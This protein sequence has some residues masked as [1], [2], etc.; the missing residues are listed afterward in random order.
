[1]LEVSEDLTGQN[2]CANVDDGVNLCMVYLLVGIV[3]G[4][5]S[6]GARDYSILRSLKCQATRYGI[7]PSWGHHNI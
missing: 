4:F 5:V 2:G 6:T 7:T 3:P 1:M